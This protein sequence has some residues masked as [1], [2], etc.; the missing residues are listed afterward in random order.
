MCQII[1]AVRIDEQSTFA[2]AIHLLRRAGNAEVVATPQ[3]DPLTDD[4][5]PPAEATIRVMVH[6]ERRIGAGEGNGPVDALDDAFRNAVNG[7]WP[8][9]DAVHLSD[10]KVRIIEAT[11]GTEAVTRVLV[12]SSDGR[13]QWNTVGVHPNVVEAS[14]LALSDAYTHAIL[15]PDW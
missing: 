5:L 1:C 13:R 2:V 12:T 6:G 8:Q 3:V 4:V 7:T 9:L 10:Y 11:S 15:R 14:W